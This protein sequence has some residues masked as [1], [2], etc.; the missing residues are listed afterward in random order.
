[1][2]RIAVFH[3]PLVFAISTHEKYLKW[4]KEKYVQVEN[5]FPTYNT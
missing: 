3:R 2:D 4:P 5:G 1:M